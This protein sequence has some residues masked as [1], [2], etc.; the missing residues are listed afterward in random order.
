L[1]DQAKDKAPSL[2]ESKLEPVIDQE[3]SLK[4]SQSITSPNSNLGDTSSSSSIMNV[5]TIDDKS[6]GSSNT[7]FDSKELSSSKYEKSSSQ[8]ATTFSPVNVFT[9][10][11]KT[12]TPAVTSASLDA[13][14]ASA[15]PATGFGFDKISAKSE[16]F[17]FGL[18]T[19]TST[20]ST[21]SGFGFAKPAL[22]STATFS[23]GSHSNINNNNNINSNKNNSNNNNNN[24]NNLNSLA[25]TSTFT[26]PS[27]EASKG[28]IFESRA[29][30]PSSGFNTVETESLKGN[31]NFKPSSFESNTSEVKFSMRGQSS[32]NTSQSSASKFFSLPSKAT[33][34]PSVT[35]NSLST[36]APNT[37]TSTGTGTFS[38]GSSQSK[39]NSFSFTPKSTPPQPTAQQPAPIQ[40]GFNFDVKS[41]AALPATTTSSSM[42]C[43]MSSQPSFTFGN[44]ALATSNQPSGFSFGQPS[45]SSNNQFVFGLLNNTPSSMSNVPSG[46]GSSAPEPFKASNPFAPSPVN[47][48]FGSAAQ[49]TQPGSTTQPEM[50]ENAV[51]SF[52]GVGSG[53][54]P[55]SQT[56]PAQPS[57]VS[58]MN[59][60]QAPSFNF[61]GNSTS[62]QGTLFQF[63]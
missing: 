11:N 6:F 46:L 35:T 33:A 1:S 17:T 38:F 26:K 27:T 48:S 60:L 28:N 57:G 63:T 31:E 43:S 42:M 47:F 52:T 19:K 3:S 37:L 8:E 40:S 49:A 45:T 30:V 5:E 62:S 56:M 9:F 39:P 34:F 24:N 54:Q 23:F 32:Q 53:T 18:D 14:S 36:L 59:F 10:G 55:N 21:S 44:T 4:K 41:T 61:A 15:K 51:F 12:V 16:G 7:K 22:S 2:N 25:T 58:Q 20:S 13:F 50:G 29:K